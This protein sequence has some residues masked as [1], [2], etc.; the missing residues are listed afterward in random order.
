M[1][2]NREAGIGRVLVS[3]LHSDDGTGGVRSYQKI[4]PQLF[5]SSIEDIER[6]YSR[7]IG[8]L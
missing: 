3:F 7:I 1:R 4:N 5:F 8:I 6:R 2:S